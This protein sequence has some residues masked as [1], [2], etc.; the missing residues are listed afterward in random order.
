M[1][2]PPRSVKI[3]ADE[4]G[5]WSSDRPRRGGTGESGPRQ[6][7][8]SVRGRVLAPTDRLRYMPGSFVAIVSGSRAA[9]D[10]FAERV[11]E[12]KAAVISRDKVRALLA[13]RV[14]DE[15]MAERADQLLDAAVAKRL[16][17][18]QSV[19]LLADGA[20]ADERERLV[21]VAHAHR[22]PRHLI[23]IEAPRDEVSDEDREGLNALRRALDAD[24]LGQEG[25]HTALRLG[26]GT[27]NE[28]KRLVF[29][30]PPEDE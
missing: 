6:A 4:R 7:D 11:V 27:I 8:V 30:P 26:G 24:Q 23:L 9:R 19:I 16:G 21:R 28:L 5:G 10:A 18:K 25:W 29:R 2:T 1:P 3:G 20:D 14:A 12:D 15:E 17:A 13:G 22:A